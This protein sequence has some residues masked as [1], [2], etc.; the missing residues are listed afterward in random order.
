MKP[1]SLV[2]AVSA[3]YWLAGQGVRALPL[4]VNQ[5]ESFALG[6]YVQSELPALRRGML[7]FAC[8]PQAQIAATHVRDI[9]LPA[10]DCPDG[11]A[12]VL[13]EVVA[14]AGDAV[15][16]NARGMWVNGLLVPRSRPLAK[17]HDGSVPVLPPP[18]VLQAGEAYLFSPHPKSFDSRYLGALRPFA[19]ARPLWTWAPPT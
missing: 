19:L 3:C 4:R 1:L 7:V 18:T 6:Y 17:T 14:I 13:K 8:A 5:T 15:R 9:H 12:P 16:V 2:I 11:R 10:G